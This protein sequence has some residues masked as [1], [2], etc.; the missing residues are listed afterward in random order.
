MTPELTDEERE[1]VYLLGDTLIPQHERGPSADEAGLASTFIDKALELRPDLVDEFR[2]RLADVRGRDVREYCDELQ[3]SDPAAFGR[4]TFVLA[5]AYLLSPKAKRW[6]HYEGQQGE[7]QD[8][9]PQP[10]YAPG[11]LLDAVRRRGP[12]YRPT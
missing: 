4:L 12:I 3:A 8:G 9:S 1:A 10:E 7:F 11:G 2:A 5:G 6:L